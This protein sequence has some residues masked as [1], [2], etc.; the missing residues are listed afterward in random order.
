MLSY[1]SYMA[2]RLFMMHRIL[3]DTGDKN[4]KGTQWFQKQIYDDPPTLYPEEDYQVAAFPK[5]I[6]H[7]ELGRHLGLDDQKLQW[8][9]KEIDCSAISDKQLL[10]H[11]GT[12]LEASQ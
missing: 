11:I 10:H 6:L 12:K 1:T 4:P 3:K 7:R 8:R 5:T 9:S 2:E